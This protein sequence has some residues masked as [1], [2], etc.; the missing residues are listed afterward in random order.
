MKRAK[1]ASLWSWSTGERGKNRVRVCERRRG[2]TLVLEVYEPSPTTRRPAVRR[3]SLGHADH[4]EAKAKAEEVA[5]ALRV[6]PTPVSRAVTLRELF[7]IY[8][9]EVT[10]TKSDMTRRH[11]RRATALFQVA[12]SADRPVRSLNRRD[13]DWF[14]RERRAGRIRPKGVKKAKAVR[15]RIIEQDVKFL[16]A[17]LNWATRAGDGHGG[18]LLERN[19]LL[20]L[21]I[22]KEENPNRPMLTAAEYGKIVAKAAAVA[23]LFE[24]LLVLAH[25]TGHRSRS[26][27][28]LRWSDVDVDARTIRW[29][30]ETD[31][32]GYEHITPASE[33]SMAALEKARRV[34]D[35][36]GDG[37]VFPSPRSPAQP[38]PR[39]RIEHWWKRAEKLAQ[40]PH[41]PGR[42]L[43]SLRR[44][45]A[46]ELRHLPMKDLQQLGGWKDHNTILKAYQHPDMD[47]MREG[48]NRRLHLVG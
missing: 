14:I 29:R 42:G 43:H 44:K 27:R 18:L 35:R 46:T 36:L 23:P 4:A 25:E 40:V 7:D 30:A 11:D 1:H 20:G 9:R 31:K 24:C 16:L 33:A 3:I 2:G 21:P 10:P 19:P 34:S 15:N 47:A 41:V 37:W 39:E 32:I 8:E 45:F 17:V 13:W 6:G 22:P 5:R 38:V 26:I 12:W 28:Y 48:L